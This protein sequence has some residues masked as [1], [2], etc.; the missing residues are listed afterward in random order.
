MIERQIFTQFLHKTPGLQQK[1]FGAHLERITDL[2]VH[3]F[4]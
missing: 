1:I 3:L 4:S 2:G